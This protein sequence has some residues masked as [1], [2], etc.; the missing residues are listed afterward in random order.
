MEYQIYNRYLNCQHQSCDFVIF[1]PGE[2]LTNWSAFLLIDILL[3]ASEICLHLQSIYIGDF[4]EFHYICNP[5]RHEKSDLIDRTEARV[6]SDHPI[7]PIQTWRTD[8][9]TLD[10]D[11]DNIVPLTYGRNTLCNVIIFCKQKYKM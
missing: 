10:I 2:L 9:D 1:V 7:I 6:W 5:C 4:I 3:S 11:I 8:F